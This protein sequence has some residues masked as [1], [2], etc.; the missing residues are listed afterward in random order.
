MRKADVFVHGRLAGQIAEMSPQHF[1]FRYDDTYLTDAS[2]PEVSL[3][4]P[5]S[6]A[7]YHSDHLFPFFFNMLSEGSNRKAQSRMLHIDSK[8]H[9]GILLATALY[10]TPGAVTVRPIDE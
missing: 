9:F 8:D 1:V 7:E 10:D 2:A 3:T 4:L 6:Q 5:K